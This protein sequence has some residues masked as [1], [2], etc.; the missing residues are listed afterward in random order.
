MAFS[1]GV[2]GVGAIPGGG[3]TRLLFLLGGFSD[4]DTATGVFSNGPR[5]RSVLLSLFANGVEIWL[6]PLVGFA[7]GLPGLRPA[8]A[9]PLSGLLVM[10][11]IATNCGFV[12]PSSMARDG[13]CDM[14]G[15]RCVTTGGRR[16]WLLWHVQGWKSLVQLERGFDF[17]S[18]ASRQCRP[19]ERKTKLRTRL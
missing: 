19:T 16:R 1:C 8:I 14:R 10:I 15:I 7:S 4:E 12:L 9:D 6:S 18:G 5:A 2:G 3:R 11:S 13:R 17:G